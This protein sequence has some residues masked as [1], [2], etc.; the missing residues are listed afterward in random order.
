MSA[1]D[2]RGLPDSAIKSAH[3]GLHHFEQEEHERE[4]AMRRGLPDE[5]VNAEHEFMEGV[6]RRA[7]VSKPLLPAKA[8]GRS[9]C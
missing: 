1:Q 9:V 5:A 6:E 2:N 8:F 3:D 4:A 7:S